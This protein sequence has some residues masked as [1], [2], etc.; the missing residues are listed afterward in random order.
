[1]TCRPRSA[2]LAALTEGS[3]PGREIA[4]PDTPRIGQQKMRCEQSRPRA[5]EPD[6]SFASLVSAARAGSPAPCRALNRHR[7]C[8]P[9]PAQRNRQRSRSPTRTKQQLQAHRPL[10]PERR[11]A[12]R[13]VPSQSPAQPATAA[14]MT[15]FPVL[16]PGYSQPLLEAPPPQAWLPRSRH[17]GGKGGL[18]VQSGSGGSPQWLPL[19][20]VPCRYQ[21]RGERQNVFVRVQE[22]RHST[23]GAEGASG[24]ES[25]T[26]RQRQPNRSSRT[27]SSSCKTWSVRPDRAKRRSYVPARGSVNEGRG[28]S[29][30]ATLRTAASFL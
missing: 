13:S 11:Q 23:G 4:A 7:V 19:R 27:V 1:V 16:L 12:A 29:H 25:S 17:R 6:S 5:S 18:R 20:P 24:G 2:G 8:I 9:K 26:S 28:T 15:W 22:N 14:P 3:P 21:R 10:P 30:S